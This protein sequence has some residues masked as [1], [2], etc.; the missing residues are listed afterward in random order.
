MGLKDILFG[1]QNTDTAASAPET[2]SDQTA[3]K[4]YTMP[5]CG[6]CKQVKRHLSKHEIPFEE[7][8]LKENKDGQKFMN[9][10]GYTGVPVTV[11]KGEEVV[12]FDL[13]K[14]N[15]LLGIK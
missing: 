9:E 7:I 2:T 15:A 10:R 4:I 12:G 5:A 8:N 6:Y 1:K 3:V 14:I 13:D 11:I